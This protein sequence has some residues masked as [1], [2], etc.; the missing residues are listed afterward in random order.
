MIEVESSDG[1]A[2][3]NRKERLLRPGVGYN[4]ASPK[5]AAPIALLNIMV[6]RVVCRIESG[7]N[8]KTSKARIDVLTN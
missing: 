1:D 5:S 4:P 7:L 6:S 2:W 8:K 3:Q